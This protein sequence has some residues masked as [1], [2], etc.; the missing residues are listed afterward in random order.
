MSDRLTDI[1]QAV[2]YFIALTSEVVST[3][4]LLSSFN[5]I[6]YIEMLIMVNSYSGKVFEWKWNTPYA[7]S[8]H[9]II[10]KVFHQP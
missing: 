7:G 2:S 6:Y 3:A 8:K 10:Q 5:Y 1:F 4:S 9:S